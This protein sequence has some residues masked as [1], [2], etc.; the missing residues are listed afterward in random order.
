MKGSAPG[1]AQETAPIWRRKQERGPLLLKLCWR[2]RRRRRLLRGWSAGG[3]D[4]ST[5]WAGEERPPA[6]SQDAG[7]WAGSPVASG[8]QGIQACACQ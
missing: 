1:P 2:L 6:A 5:A 7:E 4:E 3:K 8:L